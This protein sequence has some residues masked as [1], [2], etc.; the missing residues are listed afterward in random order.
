MQSLCFL[1]YP[2]INCSYFILVLMF[3]EQWSINR[4][5]TIHRYT[6]IIIIWTIFLLSFHLFRVEFHSFQVHFK[7]PISQIIYSVFP[8]KSHSVHTP[9][10]SFQQYSP[11]SSANIGNTN[12]KYHPIA[13]STVKYYYEDTVASQV[14][15]FSIISP[16]F[17]CILT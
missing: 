3:Q 16:E 13:H 1:I 17:I 4:I 6:H 8:P 10:S 9:F 2:I 5:F 7:F 11:S 14:N 12:F 15:A